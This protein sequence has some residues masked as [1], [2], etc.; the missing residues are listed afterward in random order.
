MMSVVVD[1]RF[2]IY[3]IL[4]QALVRRRTETKQPPSHPDI[5]FQKLILQLPTDLSDLCHG[6]NMIA[7]RLALCYFQMMEQSALKTM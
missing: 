7:L 2:A 4:W 1:A 6:L 5:F 3:Q